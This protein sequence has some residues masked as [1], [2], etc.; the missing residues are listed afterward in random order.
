MFLCESRG[1]TTRI[2]LSQSQDAFKGFEYSEWTQ[3][4]A[5]LA[6]VRDAAGPRVQPLQ[7]T[8]QARYRPCAEAYTE[9]RDA[10][11][12][13]APQTSIVVPTN[14]FGA[15]LAPAA[16]DSLAVARTER[17]LSE[18]S[19]GRMAPRF[20]LVLRSY[21]KD[22][23][24]PIGLAAELARTSVRSLQR[25]LAQS[26]RELLRSRAARALRAG[27]TLA[28]AGPDEGHRRRAVAGLRRRIAFLESF[29]THHRREPASVPHAERRRVASDWRVMA[30]L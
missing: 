2:V 21:L 16:V 20:K 24:P 4:A 5:A 11:I 3:I 23:Y 8:L 10:V 19:S 9:F 29:Q 1:S 28:G 26:G 22:G 30:G 18:L 17:L 6:I 27:H 15:K 7:L 14:L 25:E 12:V 13:G